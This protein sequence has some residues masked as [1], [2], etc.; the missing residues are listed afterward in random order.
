VRSHILTI[1]W[2]PG[3]YASP[4]AALAAAP[5]R[6]NLFGRLN[7]R[8]Y[9]GVP[10]EIHNVPTNGQFHFSVRVQLRHRAMVDWAAARP[11]WVGTAIRGPKGTDCGSMNDPFQ[12]LQRPTDEVKRALAR[13]PEL[14]QGTPLLHHRG[15]LVDAER[16]R[17]PPP[18]AP[19]PSRKP[20]FVSFDR[21][22]KNA[23]AVAA[24]GPTGGPGKP[25]FVAAT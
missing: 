5:P 23:S 11:S 15:S 24:N 22:F 1:A 20:A 9:G 17:R 12:L 8:A 10:A 6:M 25:V 3:R 21:Y 2:A 14:V 19:T 13:R 16:R 4:P 18:G 7:P